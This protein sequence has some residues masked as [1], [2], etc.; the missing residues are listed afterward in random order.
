M[1]SRNG[2]SCCRPRL[3]S[4]S[5][6][7]AR[8]RRFIESAK[9][10]NDKLW[11]GWLQIMEVLD[12][13]Q[14][15]AD[16]SGSLF[17]QTTLGEAEKLI[18]QKRVVPGDRK[19]GARDR[20]GRRPARQ[21]HHGAHARSWRRYGGPAQAERRRSK[22]SP[23][24]TCPPSPTR[25]SFDALDR[26]E[27]P[28]PARRWSPT[29]W[30]R[31]SVLE[32]LKAKSDSL[33][34][35]IE[36]VAC[37][38]HGCQASQGHAR[39]DPEAGGVRIGRRGSSWSK[40][41]ATPT[42]PFPRARRPRPKSSR[43]CADGDPDAR[44]RNSSEGPGAR[45]GGPVHDRTGAEGPVVLRAR[46]C[47][48]L[49]ETERLR[50]A[51][52]QAESYQA[53]LERDF[54]PSS[55]TRGGAEPRAGPRPAGDVRSPGAGCRRGRLEHQPGILE[56]QLDCSKSWPASSRSCCDLMSGLGEQL[57]SLIAVRNESRSLI[58]QLAASERQAELLI[59][60]NERIGRR[61]GSREPGQGAASRGRRSCCGRPGLGPTGRPCG[62]AWPRRSRT[63]RSP[64]RRPRRTSRT[65]SS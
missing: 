32:E 45:P 1:R 5:R 24:S 39:D 62:K 3:N 10:K 25:A 43:P 51:M 15:L 36:R 63:C 60:Q 52:S 42:R 53:D 12:K 48:R 55:W 33:L 47:R 37:A 64:S 54:A 58:D 23:G 2:S 14:K 31:R 34:G 65:S 6:W 49:R 44:R 7:P 28:R 61:S 11:D 22:P 18:E 57:N 59:R 35:R 29:R 50:T 40:A 19:A 20:Q 30:E 17:S 26:R 8:P 16:R 41:A 4:A 13:A 27:R 46:P 21:A 38:L 56:G 9:Q